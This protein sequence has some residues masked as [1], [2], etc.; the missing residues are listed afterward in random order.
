MPNRVV[1]IGEVRDLLKS[2]ED[3]RAKIVSGKVKSFAL[4]VQDMDGIEAIYMGGAYKANAG[5]ALKAHLRQSW[6]MTKTAE[7]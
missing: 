6:A 7:G 5:M 3:V 1:Q 4:T 2:W